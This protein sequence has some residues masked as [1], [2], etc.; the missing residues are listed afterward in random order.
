[1]KKISNLVALV[2]LVGAN[3]FTPF[4]YA[5][6]DDFV[7]SELMNVEIQSGLE[8]SS[9]NETVTELEQED[10]NN[11]SNPEMWDE[12]VGEVSDDG[13][14]SFNLS[15]NL[16]DVNLKAG[17]MGPIP[18]GTIEYNRESGYIELTYDD[19]KIR[20]RDKNVWATHLWVSDYTLL[21]NLA[22]E[23]YDNFWYNPCGIVPIKGAFPAD[24]SYEEEFLARAQELLWR[25]EPLTCE[26]AQ[27]I[28][29]IYIDINEFN[30][31]EFDKLP[32]D[33]K[34]SIV[35][36]MLVQLFSIHFWIKSLF[37]H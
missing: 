17:A 23:Y 6:L 30:K 14:S 9:E 29:E 15:E 36:S 16:R 33:K 28:K 5:Q 18:E 19:Q 27:N 7:E 31:C 2:V 13:G 11:V 24:E 8:Q 20:I 32:P 22:Y 1:M 37:F 12:E 4:S 25:S 21:L 10:F 26:D 34:Y 3:V 35:I